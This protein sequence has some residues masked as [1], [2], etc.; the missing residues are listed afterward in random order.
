MTRPIGLV[1][2]Q[3]DGGVIGADGGMPWH[4]PED[5]AH[6][7]AITL[8]NPV[9]MGRKTWDSLA[10]RFRPL[11]GRRNIVITRQ[12]DWRA[13]GADVAHSLEAALALAARFGSTSPAPTT[14]VIGGGQVFRDAIALADRL[15]VTEINGHYEGDAFAPEI[16]DSWIA[17]AADPASGWATSR[18]GVEYRFLRYDRA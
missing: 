15:E 6:F 11:P 13:D 3:A 16:D 18:T 10:P 17:A 8:G 9:V 5:L 2:A 12:P 4:V 1:W 14:W 7:K